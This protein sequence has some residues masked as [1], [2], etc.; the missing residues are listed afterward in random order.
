MPTRTIQRP[1]AV[2][3]HLLDEML[4]A[5]KKNV[6]D[7]ALVLDRAA[8]LLLHMVIIIFKNLLKLVEDDRHIPLAFCCDLRGR[9]QDFIQYRAERGMF[10]ESETHLRL[11][12]L[13]DCDAWCEIAEEFLASLQ[14]LLHRGA[15][16]LSDGFG[17]RRDEGRLAICGPKIHI[18]T[19]SLLL[20]EPAENMLN[21]RS[22]SKTALGKNKQFLVI[23]N[24]L[25]QIRPLDR[26]SVV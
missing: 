25:R 24:G 10:G 16:R 1:G 3:E 2:H 8:E 14:K 22:L 19:N 6:R 4:P 26:K 5:S 15:H 7:F 17:Y 12:F 20:G 11:A 21:K 9:G 13:V 18:C 23:S